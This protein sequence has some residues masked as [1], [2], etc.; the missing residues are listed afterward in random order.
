[1]N[2]SAL[3]KYQ[4]FVWYFCLVY[5]SIVCLLLILNFSQAYFLS[6][7]GVKIILA[8]TLSQLIVLADQFRQEGNRRFMRLGYI[9][10]L[11]ILACS[12]LGSYLL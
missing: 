2:Y 8:A 10:I 7:L 4:Q 1:M 9:L 12:A 3:I 11:V 5:L 6:H